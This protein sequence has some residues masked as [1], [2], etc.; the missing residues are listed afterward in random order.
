MREI[1][2]DSKF[3][4][5]LHDMLHKPVSI[6][7]VWKNGATWTN[8][9][10]FLES[11]SKALTQLSVEN[12]NNIRFDFDKYPRHFE[13]VH[14]GEFT[15]DWRCLNVYV[16]DINAIV[17]MYWRLESDDVIYV[18]SVFSMRYAC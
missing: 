15:Y 2:F 8:K 9:T 12:I 5:T 10:A 11:L 6:H 13:K 1:R 4:P 18:K 7:K 16:E 17:E 14:D 3:W